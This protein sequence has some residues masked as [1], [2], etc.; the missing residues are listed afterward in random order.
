VSRVCPVVCGAALRAAPLL[1]GTIGLGCMGPAPMHEGEVGRGTNLF[2]LLEVSYDSKGRET[3]ILWPLLAFHN[4]IEDKTYAFRPF[5]ILKTDP[6]AKPLSMDILFPIFHSGRTGTR[7]EFALRPLF[8]QWW[9]SKKDMT[10]VDFLFPIGWYR[11]EPGKS[12]FQLRPLVWFKRL[13][14]SGYFHLFPLYGRNWSGSEDRLW[15]LTPLIT[16]WTNRGS[17]PREWTL[18]APF[19]L[20]HLEH[21]NDRSLGWIFP[22]YFAG[23]GKKSSFDPGKAALEVVDWDL[24]GLSPLFW[25]YREIRPEG[26]EGSGEVVTRNLFVPPFYIDLRGRGS[27]FQMFGLDLYVRERRE[28]EGMDAVLW[29]LVH[30]GWENDVDQM[31]V[32]PFYWKFREGEDR[33]F[34]IWP[35]YGISSEGEYRERS[36]V[37]PLFW[38]GTDGKERSS[39]TVLG[40]LF[41]RH[42]RS[43]KEWSWDY[44]FPMGEHS[45]SGEARHSRFFPL[46]LWWGNDEYDSRHL[47]ILWPLVRRAREKDE[48]NF[49]LLLPYITYWENA[50]TGEHDFRVFWKWIRS[51]RTADL[52]TLRVNPFYRRDEN[53]RGDLYW[54]ILGGLFSRKVED[55]RTSGKI[56]WFIPY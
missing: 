52:T 30:H 12:W 4:R 8:G 50:K 51:S 49:R 23:S 39:L 15:L 2:P 42:R 3:D 56:L 43:E 17:E 7:D 20:L 16:Y 31:W 13:E 35:L 34:F 47:H 25:Q 14:S 28:R 37:Y 45:R 11:R 9:D 1:L 36:T 53:P 18:D 38:Y 44:L 6:D 22:L 26:A 46:Y 32:F 19:P 29:P 21:K 41:H 27:T 55:G 10:D 48:T 33:T 40:P 54:S 5:F 24:L